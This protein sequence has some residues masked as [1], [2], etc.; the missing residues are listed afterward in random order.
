MVRFDDQGCMEE[1]LNKHNEDDEVIQTAERLV[2][3]WP[4]KQA[5]PT[6]AVHEG[7]FVKSFP[8]DFKMGIANLYDR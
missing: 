7:R 2:Y 6:E 8:L 1:P 3:G 5:E 4:S